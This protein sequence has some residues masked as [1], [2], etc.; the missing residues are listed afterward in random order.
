MVSVYWEDLQ[1]SACVHIVLEVKPNCH[2]DF[3][4]VRGKGGAV[5]WSIKEWTKLERILSMVYIS[6]LGRSTIKGLRSYR[7]LEANQLRLLDGWRGRGGVL[8]CIKE[9]TKLDLDVWCPYQYWEDLQK[10][11]CVHIVL[12]VNLDCHLDLWVVGGKGGG[13]LW[14]I[15]QW[16]RL[17]RILMYGV[18]IGT[19]KIYNKLPAFI[20]S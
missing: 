1:K 10:S 20:L 3:W 11:V 18:H 5:L 6:V 19:G 14:S 2:Y 4:V 8:W 15:N 17:D 9:W 13:V 12:E 7:V 16:T